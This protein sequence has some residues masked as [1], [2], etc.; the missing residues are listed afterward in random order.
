MPIYRFAEAIEQP[1]SRYG[2]EIEP[3]LV[4]MLMD[5]AGGRDALPLLA[6]TLQR[7]WRQYEA[8]RRIRKANYES[9][10]KLLGLIEDAAERALRGIDPSAQQGRLLEKCQARE[11]HRRS[12][13][14]CL[15][16]RG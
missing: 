10:G 8:E 9:V 6:F 1:A 4:E 11:T 5:D 12:A 3:Q 13:C 14:S 7:L 2:V 15:R 16:W